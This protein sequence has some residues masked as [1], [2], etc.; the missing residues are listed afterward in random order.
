MRALIACE[1]SG[2]V[3][4]ALCSL[5]WDAWSCDL[6]PSESRG[7]HLQRDVRDV[8]H[9]KWDLLIAFPPCTYLCASGMHRTRR[10]MRDPR[11]TDEAVEFARMLL[12]ADIKHIAM[13]NPVGVLSSR[14]R[15]PDCVIQP[16]QFGH[17]ESKKTC[18]WLKNLPALRPTNII[19]K[20]A[21][22]RWE[23]QTP[24]GQDATMPSPQRVA[25]RSR[26]YPGVAAAMAAQWSEYVSCSLR[27]ANHVRTAA[28]L[29]VTGA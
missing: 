13:E 14:I 12:N 3:R 11:L 26:T 2:R 17:P 20:S 10:G 9:W 21:G 4:D 15:I 28:S 27:N 22:T 23:N 16:W 7:N 5:G 8:L 1:F 6:L 18:L 19:Q 24:S 25:E 29:T